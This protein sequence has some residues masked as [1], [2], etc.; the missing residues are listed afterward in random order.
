MF[1]PSI[2]WKQESLPAL[3]WLVWGFKESETDLF[4]DPSHP[5]RSLT[6]SAISEPVT[7]DC[8]QSSKQESDRSHLESFLL[9]ASYNCAEQNHVRFDY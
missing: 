4:L 7:E 5:V 8:I 3:W 1:Q 6:R 2:S 9:R